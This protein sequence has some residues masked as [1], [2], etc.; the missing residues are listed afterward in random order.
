MKKNILFV[1]LI[2]GFNLIS[3]SLDLSVDKLAKELGHVTNPSTDPEDD[4]SDDGG[5]GGPGFVPS[6][7]LT[8]GSL[9][10]HFRS[11]N[12]INAIYGWDVDLL[13]ISLSLA[14]IEVSYTGTAG[15]CT[16]SLPPGYSSFMSIT[17]SGC[18]GVGT[19]TL[20][21]KS[22]TAK[23][24]AGAF[25][26]GLGPITRPFDA[27]APTAPTSVV[28]GTPTSIS[29]SPTITYTAGTDADTGIAKHQV[30]IE[31]T[32]SPW[33]TIQDWT[34]HVSGTAVTGLTLVSGKQYSVS[35]RAQ[36]VAGNLSSQ[37][38]TVNF[39]GY[40]PTIDCSVGTPA[41]GAL[42]D[43]GTVYAGTFDGGQY[44]VTPGGCTDS[45]T[46]IC[47]GGEDTLQK[48]WNN[49]T[50]TYSAVPGTEKIS[51]AGYATKSSS[52]FRGDVGSAAIVAHH[53]SAAN[54]AKYCLDMDYGGHQDWYLPSKSELAY[55]YCKAINVTG[56][57][58]TS[59][60]NEDPNCVGT[61]GGKQ[62]ILSGF[63]GVN[64]W[65]S[66]EIS[67]LPGTYAWS[68]T[69]ALG[70]QMSITQDMTAYLR[71]VRRY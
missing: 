21:V 23:N 1:L 30:R 67:Q 37:S 52:S 5:G 54:A 68:H 57:H 55:I 66:T 31:L 49:G 36:D 4:D 42:C 60:P 2:L 64:Y 50:A 41:I 6:N 46:P 58:M 8:F 26:N 56:M 71:C 29:T 69:F 9:P 53:G 39:Y 19:L 34:D 3:C 18:T 25:V 61:P 12:Y 15:G 44:M 14:D 59:Y 20:S 48:Y 11:Y 32:Q 70:S 28:L 10:T 45:P 17:L 65:S 51:I 13:T 22:G 63:K 47:A 40:T 35:V 24:L 7:D 33:T 16:V 38:S 43:E 27:V 62:A